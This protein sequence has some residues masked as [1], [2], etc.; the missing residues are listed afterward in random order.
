MKKLFCL[1]AVSGMLFFAQESFAQNTNDN[2]AT[3]QKGRVEVRE[4]T[5]TKKS[6]TPE[7]RAQEWTDHLVK[8]LS[9]NDEQRRKAQAINLASA[10]EVAQIKMSGTREALKAAH[11]KREQEIITILTPSQKVQFEKA[12]KQMKDKRGAVK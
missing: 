6:I 1:L 4:N 5:Q 10:Q 3:M 2:K 11:K 8:K 9:L 12:K 7:V